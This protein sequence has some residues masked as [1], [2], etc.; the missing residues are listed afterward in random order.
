MKKNL[1]LFTGLGTPNHARYST[2]YKLICRTAKEKM[3][4]ET[5]VCDWPGHHSFPRENVLNL[6]TAT[7]AGVNYIRKMEQ[8]QM[9]YVLIGTSFGGAVALQAVKQFDELPYLQK[10]VAWAIVPYWR[11][12]KGFVR[13]IKNTL[14]SAEKKKHTHVDPDY[15]QHQIPYEVLLYEYSLDKPLVAA[16]GD[17]DMFCNPAYITYLKDVIKNPAIL[18]HVVK[19]V[20]HSVR[21]PNTEY[22]NLLLD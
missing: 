7:K 9:P 11:T 20:V 15:Y 13:D 16:I 21:E 5:V 22:L 8:K 19:D 10:I 2:T 1:L 17:N 14:K 6:N 18:F 3:Y 4:N 12:Y